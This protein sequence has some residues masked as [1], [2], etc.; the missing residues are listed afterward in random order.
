M[1]KDINL[2][3]S[4]INE[5]L[6]D[7]LYSS[8]AKMAEFNLVEA[9]FDILITDDQKLLEDSKNCQ[10]IYLGKLNDSD[11]KSFNYPIRIGDLYDYILSLRGNSEIIFGEYSLIKNQKI[12]KKGDQEI[13]LTD[14][15]VD[16]IVFLS[17][18]LSEYISKEVLLKE[19]WGYRS[20][21]TTHTLETHIYRLRQKIGDDNFLNFDNS[22]YK[23]L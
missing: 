21:I 23:L 4:I 22:G 3:L 5:S 19:V 1:K 11:Y 18:N 14:K 16:I 8:F 7:F 20:D 13:F 12:L 10:Y 2:K 15:E 6:Q 17:N 9:E